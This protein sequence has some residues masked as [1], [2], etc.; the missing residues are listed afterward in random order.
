ML[1]ESQEA[2]LELRKRRSLWDIAVR[3]VFLDKGM[4]N[5]VAD[6]RCAV[7]RIEVREKLTESREAR[8]M[9]PH[10]QDQNSTRR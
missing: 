1:L 10:H 5:P 3:R 8:F 6:S 2:V 4:L 7:E 9:P